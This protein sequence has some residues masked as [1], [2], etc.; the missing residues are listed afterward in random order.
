MKRDFIFFDKI[1]SLLTQVDPQEM[2]IFFNGLVRKGF[3][4]QEGIPS[5]SHYPYVSVIIPV[6]NRP[7]DITASLQSLSRLDYPVE[8]IEVIVVDD[9][10]EDKTPEVISTFP[11]HL[12]RFNEH[13]QASF[14]RNWAAQRAKGEILAF[15]DSDCVADP[16]WLKELIP[17]FGDPLNGAVG[18]VVDSYGNKKGLDRYEKVKSS[19]TMGS[20]PK[21]SRE[22]KKFFYFPS[23]NLLVRR[24]LFLQLGGFRE[25]M[26]VGED[27]DFCW[28]LQDQGHHIEYRPVGKI[29]HKHRDS[30]RYFCS[31]RFDYGTSEPLLQKSHVKRIKQF[32]FPIKDCVFWS[33][34]FLA[35]VSGWI[36]WFALGG[37]IAVL[38]SITKLSETRKN[39]IPIRLP[40]LLFVTVRSYCFFFYHFCAFVSRYYL[41]WSPVIFMLARVVSAI[42]F[43]MHLLTGTAEYFIKKPDLNLPLFLFYFTADQLAYQLGVWWGCLKI[44]CF[45]PVNP[46]L[47]RKPFREAKG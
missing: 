25:D 4:E 7:E 45:S 38:D 19:L 27:V 41:I 28:R 15:L 36:P 11:V 37:V 17:A 29:Y 42:V 35:I 8:K 6:R 14:C 43:C 31:R 39:N 46:Y 5:I 47:V 24:A 2:E 26:I 12:I 33:F 34:I 30:M 23:C 20:W 9:A 44:L 32:F 3:L 10:S 21:S 13:K 40:G 1:V 16:L 18:G 22:E